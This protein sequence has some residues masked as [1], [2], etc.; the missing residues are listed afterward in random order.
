MTHGFFGDG[1]AAMARN[2]SDLLR[3]AGL[4]L[5]RSNVLGIVNSLPMDELHFR[6]D[7]PWLGRLCNRALKDAC[8]RHVGTPEQARVRE[9]TDYF[10]SFALRDAVA[11]DMLIA[12]FK[13]VLSQELEG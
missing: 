7:H 12:A 4:P 11:Q 10:L 8:E 13:G 5:T 3:L 6:D 1:C 9:L 2:I